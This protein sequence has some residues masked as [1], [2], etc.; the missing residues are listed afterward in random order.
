MTLLQLSFAEDEAYLESLDG[1]PPRLSDQQLDWR[2]KATEGRMRSRCCGLIEVQAPPSEQVVKTV[3]STVGP[4]YRTVVDF[5]RTPAIWNNLMSL[6]ARTKF[7]VDHAL[8]TSTLSEMRLQSQWPGKVESDSIALCSMLRLLSYERFMDMGITHG[9]YLPKLRNIIC[10]VWHHSKLYAT[11]MIQ[12]E[13]ITAT[14]TRTCHQFQLKYPESFIL[15]AAIQCPGKHLGALVNF[16]YPS[17]T[18]GAKSSSSKLLISAYLLVQFVDEHD[19]P[20]RELIANNI[21]FCTDKGPNT[22][23]KINRPENCW[24]GRW[25]NATINSNMHGFTL[26]KFALYYAVF[27]NECAGE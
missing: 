16:Y 6:T 25:K 1:P 3:Q 14:T 26:W 12:E 5:L 22:A 13:T 24:N 15:F 9:A 18:Q 7:H 17:E 27:L 4:F 10:H 23:I 2:Y 21:M 8:L 20:L 11:P 19:P